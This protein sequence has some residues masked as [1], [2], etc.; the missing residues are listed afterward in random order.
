MFDTSYT[1]LFRLLFRL[2]QDEIAK[3]LGHSTFLQ[4][5]VYTV[6]RKRS[7]CIGRRTCNL[8]CAA[9]SVPS[10]LAVPLSLNFHFERSVSRRYTS[11]GHL[12]DA[13]RAYDWLFSGYSRIANDFWTIL[14]RSP[15]GRRPSMSTNQTHRRERC[16]AIFSLDQHPQPLRDHELSTSSRQNS[17]LRQ[18]LYAELS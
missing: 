13:F 4:D 7:K 18:I 10:A 1:R 3:I 6:F 15:D 5:T 17:A 9:Y 8:L 12:H 16:F 14:F 2:S 11:D